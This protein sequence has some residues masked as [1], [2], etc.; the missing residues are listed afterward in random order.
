MLTWMSLSALLACL[1]W[2]PAAQASAP[3]SPWDGTNPFNCTLQD[4]GRGTTVPDPAAD[5]YCVHFDKTNQNVTELGLV[6]FLS[7]E[8]ARTAAAYPKCFYF[9]SDHWRGSLIQADGT[10]ELYE[11]YGHYFF[12]KATGDGGVWV[13]GFNV[14]HQTFDP[15][16]FPGF[17]PADGQ[18]FGPGTGGFIT[19]D[20]VPADPSC[21]AMAKAHPGIYASATSVPRCLARGGVVNRHGLGALRL[22][23]AEERVRAAAGPPQK[24]KRGFLSYCVTGGGTVAIGEP[25]DRS[26]TLGSGGKARAV[27]LLTS[28]RTFVLRGPGRRLRVGAWVARRGWR[29]WRGWR[30]AARIGRLRWLRQGNLLIAVR[31]RRVAWLGT[32]DRRSIR[33]ASAL[34]S[35]LRRAGP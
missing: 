26:G 31:R 35:Y 6:G 33:T 5:P 4:A 3:P 13:A 24:V 18:Y 34:R 19:H 32:Y 22:G 23:M 21:V 29:G 20:Q 8:P 16:S 9:Q 11:F 2:A 30:T 17:P 25:G 15:S 14:N 28:S 10:T 12:D 7:L 1:L 27:M